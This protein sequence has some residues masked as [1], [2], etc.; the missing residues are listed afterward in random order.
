[1]ETIGTR[2]VNGRA[3]ACVL[4]DAGTDR[5]AILCHGFR[6]SMIG[7]NRLFV[8]LA[9][10]LEA[11][12][13][14]C[15]RFD[16]FGSGNSGGSF[17]DSSFDDWVRTIVSLAEEYSSAG[18]RVAL[19]GQSMGG[20]AVICAAA[21]LDDGIAGVGAWVPGVNAA[22]PPSAHPD[23]LMEEGAQVVR[24]SFWHEAYR[25]DI[26][27]AFA[28]IVAPTHVWLATDDEFISREEN[29][30]LATVAREH[31][32]VTI[33]EGHAHSAWTV[34]QA[35]VVLSQTKDFVRTTLSAS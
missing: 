3:L 13:I 4:N 33:L 15:L 9:R 30:R 14:S 23:E 32:R 35:E 31:Q 8:R 24:W 18:N 2:I 5:I 25:A 27:G 28:S 22:S 19:V 17:L 16:Q 1:M 34:A 11:E 12:G 26:V 6:S 10:D 7:P 29:E 21:Q 20:A